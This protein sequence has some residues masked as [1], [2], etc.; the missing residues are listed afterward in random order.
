MYIIV[1]I[2]AGCVMD[3]VSLV[4]RFYVLWRRVG[5]K[6]DGELA[7][8]CMRTSKNIRSRLRRAIARMTRR[9]S[10]SYKKTN[11]SSPCVNNREWSTAVLTMSYPTYLDRSQAI[12]LRA[13]CD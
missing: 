5:S 8:D 11:N 7:V 2:F 4:S 13:Y 9:L 10:P 6:Q 1:V 3:D 12:R